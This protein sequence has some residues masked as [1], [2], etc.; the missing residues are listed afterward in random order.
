MHPDRSTNLQVRADLAVAFI[1]FD[2][3]IA[4]MSKGALRNKPEDNQFPEEVRDQSTEALKRLRRADLNQP[5]DVYVAG[6]ENAPITLP[7]VVLQLLTEI[8]AKVAADQPVSIVT[9][10]TI[11]T[12]QQAAEMLNVSRPYVIKL[13][14]E[15]KLHAEK[16]GRHRRI[17]ASDLD[18]YRRRQQAE[19]RA[20]A[21]EMTQLTA[22]WDGEE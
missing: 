16:V 15:H 9:P 11:F 8:L 12:T 19:A 3:Y 13:I 22:D 10:D 5:V 1:A 6:R 2:S 4:V 21:K 18:N 20:A 14:D 7:P 17:K